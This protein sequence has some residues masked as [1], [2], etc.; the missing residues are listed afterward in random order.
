M[1][2]WC[3]TRSTTSGN[4]DFKEVLD[5]Q[6]IMANYKHRLVGYLIIFAMKGRCSSASHALSSAV[7]HSIPAPSSGLH[8]LL[9]LVAG[10]VSEGWLAS[11]ARLLASEA[12]PQTAA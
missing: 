2:R 1:A 7:R 10:S 11:I 5:H 12:R 4:S 9:G 3:S 8:A 6:A